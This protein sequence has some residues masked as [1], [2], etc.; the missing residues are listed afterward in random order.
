MSSLIC[1]H[2]MQLVPTFLPACFFMSQRHI[3][4]AEKEHLEGIMNHRCSMWVAFPR[5]KLSSSF[6]HPWLPI[7]VCLNYGKF[8]PVFK[9]QT[10]S[11][12]YIKI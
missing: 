4:T 6:C 8:D 12:L 3:I 10:K 2:V 1:M 7:K 9:L 11:N 5:T